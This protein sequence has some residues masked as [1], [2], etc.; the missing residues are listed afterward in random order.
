[1]KRDQVEQ[2]NQRLLQLLGSR[3]LLVVNEMTRFPGL[4]QKALSRGMFLTP[5]PLA[6]CVQ[7]RPASS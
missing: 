6:S 7:G 4:E 1:M 3:K 5:M 2:E